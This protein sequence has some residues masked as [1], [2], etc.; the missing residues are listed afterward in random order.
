MIHGMSAPRC[1]IDEFEAERTVE[2]LRPRVGVIDQQTYRLAAMKADRFP[3]E[4]CSQP[5]FTDG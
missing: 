3:D 1:L 5:T 4:P 2:P